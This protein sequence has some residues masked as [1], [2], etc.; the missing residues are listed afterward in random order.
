MKSGLVSVIVPV[1]NVEEY[2]DRCVDSILAQTYK[3]IEI[4]LVNDGSSDSSGSL[5]KKNLARDSRIVVIEK[6][7]G[8]LSSARNAGLDSMRGEYLV[9]VDSDD[10][11]HPKMIENMLNALILNS[12]EIVECGIKYVSDS[13]NE[14]KDFK[15]S[16]VSL[17]DYKKIDHNQAVL[18]CLDYQLKIMSWNKLYKASMFDNL[19]FPVGMLNEDEFTTPFIID[20]CTSYLVMDDNY[21]AYVHRQGSIMHSK[22]SMKR[23]DILEAFQHRL[24]YFSLKYHRKYDEVIMYHYFL[25]C[26]NL[27]IIMDS[28]HD[29]RSFRKVYNNLFDV[30]IFSKKLSVPKKA[31]IIMYRLFPKLMIE[32][33]ERRF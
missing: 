24:K 12:V 28:Q 11:I 13:R 30:L 9:F 16:R 6:R 23:F 29:T 18:K 33:R 19:R 27:K 2:L 31:K 4:I 1:Y 20:R 7:N 25:A 22:F 8:G 17:S 32:L 14:E 10:Y 3:N 15:E 5:C 26:V 21:Y